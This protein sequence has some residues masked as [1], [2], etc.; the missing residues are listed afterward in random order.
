[1]SLEEELVKRLTLLERKV[2][3]LVKPEKAL[4]LLSETI[5]TGSAATVTFSS[6]PSGFRNLLISSLARTDRVAES[7]SVNL[8][9]NADA[10]ANY[11][12]GQIFG[13][14]ATPTASVTRAGTSMAIAVA[15][16]ASS[17]A[18]TFGAGF[19]WIFGYSLT[20]MEK[21]ALGL[22]VNYGDLSADADMFTVF[23]SG[24]WRN[25]AAITSITVL[26]SVGPNFVSGSRFQLYG[27]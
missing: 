23:R 1:L 24:G 6:I 5:L 27:M 4:S 25:T 17:R 14:S 2:D 19:I 10:G 11:D 21:K 18:S 9:F 12:F 3:A 15:E 16:G 8:R 26:P 22:S 7:D 13:N 20:T